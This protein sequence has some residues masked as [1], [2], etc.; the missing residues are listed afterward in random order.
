V[1]A[2]GSVHSTRSTC[3]YCGTGCGVVIDSLDGVI[4]AVRGDENHPANFGKLCTKGSTLALTM[5]PRAMTGRA[6]TPEQRVSREAPR[7]QTT[8]DNALATIAQKFAHTIAEHGPDAVGFYVS[9]Q[10]L[11]EDYYVFNKLAKGLIGTNNIDTNSRL[12][13]SSAVTGYQQ[14]LGVDAPPCSYED[15]DDATCLFIAGSNTAFA[16]PIL[17]RRIEAAKEKNPALK[18]IV[19]DPR[20]TETAAFADLFLPILP[21]TDVALF[22]AMLHV[23]LWEEWC[24][25]DYIAAHT[26][27]FDL[28]RTL[29]RELSP[30]IAAEICGVPADDIITAARWFAQSSATLSLYCQGLNQSTSG[31]AKNASLINLHLATGQIGKVGAGPFSL[32]GQPNAMGGREVGG[33]ATTLA[34]HRDIANTEHR[35]EVRAFWGADTIS[36]KRGKTAVEMFDAAKSGEIKVLWIVCTNPAQSLPDLAQVEA[37]FANAEMV[38]VQDAYRNTETIAFADIVLPATSWGEKDGTVTNSE[39]RISRVRAAL[40]ALGEARH[41]WQI[42]RDVGRLL[43]QHLRPGKPSMF[44]FASPEDAFNEH[45]ALTAGRDLDITGLSYDLLDKDGP[46]QWPFA[47][48]AATGTKRLYMDGKFQTASGRAHFFVAKYQPTADKVDAH[49]PLRLT[50]GRLRDQWHGMSRTGTVASLYG[51]APAPRLTMNPHDLERRGFKEDDIVKVQSR[52]GAIFVAVEA[53]PSLRSGQVY[54]P[55]H[56]GKRFLGGADS[57]GVNTLTTS[58]FDA[59]S[60]QPELK[61]AAVKVVAANLAW[62]LVAF[63]TCSTT[64]ADENNLLDQ[65]QSLQA[66][67][68]YFSNTLIGRDKPGVLIHA[69]NHGAPPSAWLAELD[70]ILGLEDT[71][72]LR[73]EDKRRGSARRILV[74][75]DVL[76]AVRLSGDAESTSNATW[77]RDWLLSGRPVADIRRMLLSPVTTAPIGLAPMS[78]VVCQCHDVSEATIRAQLAVTLGSTTER[79][80]ILNNKLKCGTECGSCLPELRSMIAATNGNS[81]NNNTTASATEEVT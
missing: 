27:G 8:W 7:T 52:R 24:D 67:V 70:T 72:T 41:D 2:V 5:Q 71:N 23:M 39:R 28:L 73:Y 76:I 55:M 11:T 78:R 59:Y 60:R 12:C 18:I 66:N 57:S 9:G 16:H 45:R 81:S 26:E 35:E 48:G 58:A 15:I 64:A 56:W 65:L 79:L 61:H 42:A 36:D 80:A 51:T 44:A 13:M 30:A 29:V 1:T 20:R 34:A 3:C 33:M 10:L 37:A 63:R 53:S 43:E 46:Q 69:A 47:A 32:T 4:T 49:Y 50:T 19:V 17:F 21:G 31:T 40:P 62:H 22:H 68:A 74:T 75:S 25:R 38:I 6:R 54:L 77:L 14:T